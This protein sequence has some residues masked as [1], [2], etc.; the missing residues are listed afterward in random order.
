MKLIIGLGNPGKEYQS[1]RHNVGFLVIDAL[2]ERYGG[3]LQKET[4]WNALI[5]EVTI[6]DERIVLMQPQ[7]FMNNSGES[8]GSYVRYY[9]IDPSDVWVL[10][11]DLDLPFGLVRMRAEGSSGGH[12]GLKSITASLGSEAYGRIRVGIGRGEETDSSSE[13]AIYVLQPFT[14]RELRHLGKINETLCRE[15]ARMIK[16]KKFEH[17]SIQVDE[18]P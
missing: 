13:A 5:G 3:T 6:E 17:H 18:S 8:V 16:M 10:S 11:D 15:I 12:N 2:A 1:T 9:Q 4:K 7:T 14:D